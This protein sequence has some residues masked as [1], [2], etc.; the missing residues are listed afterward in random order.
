MKNNKKEVKAKVNSLAESAEEV[1]KI[2]ADNMLSGSKI[3]RTSVLG[4]TEEEKDT[5]EGVVKDTLNMVVE[6]AETI[7]GAVADSL[8]QGSKKIRNRL[9][10]ENVKPNSEK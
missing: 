4:T 7:S 3:I 6:T 8:L 1:G 9:L 10:D 5:P 2:I